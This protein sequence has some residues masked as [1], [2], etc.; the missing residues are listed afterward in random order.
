MRVWG[1]WHVLTQARWPREQKEQPFSRRRSRFSQDVAGRINP[2]TDIQ[3]SARGL[4]GDRK[5]AP[6]FTV[7]QL[8]RT[9]A[10]K[11]MGTGK[12]KRV[13][14]AWGRVPTRNRDKNQSAVSEQARQIL[15]IISGT[16]WPA[17]FEEAWALVS[18]SENKSIDQ[19]L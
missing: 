7:K 9:C 4:G 8:V 18:L 14:K 10:Q 11:V 15:C 5:R 3:S 17:D 16:E 13:A 19:A 1:G 2:E 12:L 6:V